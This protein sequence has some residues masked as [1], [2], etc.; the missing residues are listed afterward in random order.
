ME[1]FKEFKQITLEKEILDVVRLLCSD[2]L[3]YFNKI[4][5]IKK[6]WS[7]KETK[8]T[9]DAII[10]SFE[11]CLYQVPKEF[12]KY[13]EG[14]EACTLLGGQTILINEEILINLD[15]NSKALLVVS[16]IHEIAHILR[17]RYV[18]F[19]N[20]EENTPKIIGLPSPKANPGKPE[21]GYSIER[22]IFKYEYKKTDI[23]PVFSYALMNYGKFSLMELFYGNR[24]PQMGNFS[25]NVAKI[26]FS[27]AFP[28]KDAYESAKSIQEVIC[29][30]F[31]RVEIDML[32]FVLYRLACVLLRVLVF[33]QIFE[34]EATKT[35][36]NEA[37][38]QSSS[39]FRSEEG[40]NSRSL[41]RNI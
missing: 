15:T 12:F 23:S 18:A 6:K 4:H 27:T 19:G 38:S 29:D 25:D 5:S 2:Y 16:I 28:D 33:Q 31:P 20:L 22:Q 10:D 39:P 7:P 17:L 32:E 37:H 21:A 40:R 13:F 9:L 41:K 8:D 34:E 35:A 3:L 11:S 1:R 24:L 36:K 30:P 26:F 14:N